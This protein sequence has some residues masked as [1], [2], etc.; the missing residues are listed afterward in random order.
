M[1]QRIVGRWV[2]LVAGMALVMGMVAQPL[3]AS[4][5]SAQSARPSPQF[6]APGGQ[7]VG[8][9][10]ESA[11][12]YSDSLGIPHIYSPTTA[13]MWFGDGWAQ[14]KDRM[15]QLELTRAAVLG[16]LSKLFG[17]GQL[18][19]D[20][21]QRL[22]YYSSAEYQTQYNALPAATQAALVAYANGI[23]AY[24]TQAFS[25][26]TN[27]QKMVPVEF[28][29]LGHQYGLSGPYQP[30]PWQPVDSLAVG[31][32]LTRAFGTG[33]GSELQNLAFLQKME[34]SFVAAGQSAGTAQANAT[35]VLYDAMSIKDPTAPT[36]VATT[37]ANGPVLT[38][39]TQSQPGA[40]VAP[41]VVNAPTQSSASIGAVRQ[42]V[43]TSSSVTS[44]PP[45]AVLQA[46]NTLQADGQ[47][48]NNR[49][50]SMKIF[51]H[52]GSDA[53]AV[54]PWRS[55]DH[56]ALLWGAPQEGFGTP[57]V[58]YE[59][60][61]HGPSYS[62]SG[63]AI[64]GEPFVLIG[65]NADISWM[66][67]SEETTNEA[68]FSEQVTFTTGT[69]PVPST[70]LFNGQQ[71]PVQVV[72]EQIP[73]LGASGVTMQ[74]YAIY[75]TNN[76][77]IF[78]TD[79][80]AGI[81]FS[82]KFASWMQEYK[83]LAGFSQFGGDTNLSQFESSV[84]LI[85][86]VHNFMYA[87]RQGNIAFFSAGL[88]PSVSPTPPITTPPTL[89]TSGSYNALL[90]HNGNGTQQ[91]SL[92]SPEFIPFAQMPHSINPGQGYLDNWNTV[93][94][95]QLFYQPDE[96]RGT[97]FRSQRIS[98]MLSASSTINLAYLKQVEHS[99]GTID[100]NNQTRP[101]A[102]YLIPY[103]EA[104]Y[105]KLVAAGDPLV[106]STTN[107]ALA[108][109]MTALTSWNTTTSIGSPAMSIFNQFM[110]ALDANVFAGG[111]NKVLP[112]AVSSSEQQYVGPLNLNYPGLGGGAYNTNLDYSGNLLLHILDGANGQYPCNTL[113][114]TGHY[115]GGHRNHILVESLDNALTIL[116]GTG[117]QIGRSATGF[118]TTSVAQWGW[119]PTQ[120]IQWNNLDPVASAAGV[121]VNCGTSAAQERSSYFIAMDMAPV[122]FG[123][124]LMAPGESGFISAAGVPS[125]H[126]CDQV[127]L[128]NTFHYAPMGSSVSEVS[129]GTGLPTGGAAVTITGANL[130]GATAVDFG[131]V[132]ATSFTVVSPTEITAV[133]PAASLSTVDV[134][135]VTPADP[136][137]TVANSFDQ[138]T[139]QSSLPGAGNGYWQ[140]ASDGGVFSF[141]GAAFHGSMGG[142]PLNEPIV[143]M[144][145]TPDGKGYWL[146]ASDGGIFAFGDAAF[147][148]SMG[149]HSL[150]RP[151]V[152]MAATP[153]GKGYWEVASDGGIFAFGDARFFGSMGANAPGKPVVGVVST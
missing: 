66:T 153:D 112:G 107:P 119:Q 69:N 46:A 26:T 105:Q 111:V 81:A 18:A 85:A 151:I 113:C 39:P 96:F 14:A 51:S 28:W 124:Q 140:V 31:V 33:G 37:C 149:G 110:E 49:G 146:V 123:S 5:A 117:P 115:F 43:A 133:S 91:W 147:Y 108:Q 4:A 120:G 3:P 67:T 64:A 145:S 129:P 42:Q 41:A 23:N 45:S 90:P 130:T 132:P 29:A 143:G 94:S 61:L 54:A 7:T 152:G 97:V 93:P 55:A 92:Q 80:S 21:A 63:M 135:V 27:Q 53:Y 57:S 25:N 82:M 10:T 48:F 65:R 47:L 38:S 35:A 99:I 30:S 87:D 101:Y 84:S 116:S 73:V 114:Y 106:S 150:N 32:Y 12:I 70:Y 16:R 71:V 50:T 95:S 59:V 126:F 100:G 136:G 24:E 86:T 74:P 134:R 122:P 78:Q 79:P 36:T 11:T 62:A 118:G 17:S 20:Q 1:L 137:G 15:F 89:S 58:N 125:P 121:T 9:G 60:F 19:T 13:G 56:H 34:A 8:S 144:A 127:T 72:N 44:L 40:C 6:S 2:L 103:L 77:P 68:V 138:F 131:A 75:R 22:F 109:A 98:Q 102:S 141:G 142:T 52:W 104:A 88:V 76:G 128:F 83:S 139:Y 148:G